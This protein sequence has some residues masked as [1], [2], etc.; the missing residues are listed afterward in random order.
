[1]STLKHAVIGWYHSH[2]P[3]YEMIQSS[4][5]RELEVCC[6]QLLASGP[7]QAHCAV[8]TDAIPESKPYLTKI[9][10]RPTLAG[11]HLS[12]CSVVGHGNLDHNIQSEQLRVKGGLHFDID[13]QPCAAHLVYDRQHPEGL[14][15]ALLAP[16]LHELELAIW[17]Y[18][19]DNLFCVV[20]PQVDALM[21][22][23]ILHAKYN[24]EGLVRQ[25][26]AG[27]VMASTIMGHTH[28]L[29]LSYNMCMCRQDSAAAVM[30]SRSTSS[31]PCGPLQLG[32]QIS[33]RCVD[34]RTQAHQSCRA[35]SPSEHRMAHAAGTQAH[36]QQMQPHLERII[37]PKLDVRHARKE[38]LHDDLAV[39]ITPKHAALVA[40]E[41]V[42][43]LNDV[44]E[45]LILLVAQV[46]L[47]PT[48][49][50]RHLHMS[51]AALI[52]LKRPC[53]LPQL[54]RQ[55]CMHGLL[56]ALHPPSP[57][58][59]SNMRAYTKKEEIFASN[60]V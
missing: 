23:H 4:Q 38:D 37:E 45:H 18:K 14:L 56:K 48:H 60:T 55:A 20:A 49:R 24:S 57:M 52:V 44:Q 21:E 40:H 1:M 3:A 28:T 43:L 26:H 9:W 11:L 33:D 51:I 15:D 54:C 12:T 50:S 41:H 36:A 29:N 5:Q 7:T 19:A 47:A 42:D 32:W 39:D 10:A 16:V 6:R 8:L 25:H 35:W 53:L 22:G 17:R 2:C 46:V 58:T 31:L 30:T 34:T 13:L 59:W 27:I